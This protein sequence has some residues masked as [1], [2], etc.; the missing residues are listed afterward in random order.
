MGK[1]FG[2][3]SQSICDAWTGLGTSW[4]FSECHV[5]PCHKLLTS[6]SH[7]LLAS[8]GSALSQFSWVGAS[9]ASAASVADRF[10]CELSDHVR[11]VRSGQH[12]MSCFFLYWCGRCVIFLFVDQSCLLHNL[13]WRHLALWDQWEIAES[14]M[15][16]QAKYSA[17][18][19]IHCVHCIH[20]FL[21]A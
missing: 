4:V 21:S 8:H 9:A 6:S 19:C 12:V 1:D 15:A 2:R 13:I 20:C 17:A 14:N 7:V 3:L 11:P 10:H 5:S 18:N 16:A